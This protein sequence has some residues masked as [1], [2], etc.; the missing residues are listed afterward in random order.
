[1]EDFDPAACEEECEEILRENIAICRQKHEQRIQEGTHTVA[2]SEQL[3]ENCIAYYEF[4]IQACIQEC[5]QKYNAFL[6]E[7]GKK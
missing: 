4:V 3:L 7:R 6:Y 1:M 2:E 5:Q